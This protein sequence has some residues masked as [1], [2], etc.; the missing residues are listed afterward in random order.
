MKRIE[1]LTADGAAPLPPLAGEL[2]EGKTLLQTGLLRNTGDEPLSSIRLRV[3]NTATVPATLSAVVG[4]VL[5]GEELREV[6]SGPLAPGESVPLLL[7][8]TAG[9]SIPVA[10][11][12]ATLS[13]EYA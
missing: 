5:L 8:W 10:E 11:D 9:P 2:S 4:G 6:L 12:S 13:G 1:L 7:T 3:N